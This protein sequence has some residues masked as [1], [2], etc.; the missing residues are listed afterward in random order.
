M[1]VR[2]DLFNAIISKAHVYIEILSFK[3]SSDDCY[4]TH[5][6]LS[7][8]HFVKSFEM[9]MIIGLSKLNKGYNICLSIQYKP[10]IG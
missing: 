10:L 3:N 1:L 5:P 6:A 8:P 2:T 7:Y 4:F 9:I